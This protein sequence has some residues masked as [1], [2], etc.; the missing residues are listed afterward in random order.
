MTLNLDVQA[1]AV[2]NLYGVAFDLSYPSNLLRFDGVDE[3]PFLAA[4]GV[5]TELLSSA[6]G[7]TLVIGATR[8]GNVAG[9][10]GSGVLMTLRFTAVGT[11]NGTFDFSSN[12]AFNPAGNPLGGITWAGGSV[13]TQL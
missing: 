2:T 11:G 6:S 5:S 8:L 10:S 12:Q 3:G 9:V 1:D 4:Q 7:G 13:R